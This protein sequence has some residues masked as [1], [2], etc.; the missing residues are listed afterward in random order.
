MN[1]NETEI[2][3]K[4]LE[5]YKNEKERIRNIIGQIGGST[6]KKKDTVINLIFLCII[7]FLFTFDVVREI[8]HFNIPWLPQILSIELAVLL[9]SLKI[10]W[11]IHKQSK[12]DHFQFWIL[13]S[14]EFQIN[15]ITKSVKKLE[16]KLEDL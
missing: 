16:K 11:M 12:I 14:I 1:M 4:E 15:S 9:V 13:N 7:I 2:L 6:S 5:H 8:N 10:I 3:R